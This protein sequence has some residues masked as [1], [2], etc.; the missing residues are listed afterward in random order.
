MVLT[1]FAAAAAFVG[2]NIDDI[3]VLT[4]LL[5]R[6]SGRWERLRV[7]AGYLSGVALLTVLSLL[8]AAGLR[9]V[10]GGWL[11][12]LGLIPIALGVRAA[13]ARQEDGALLNPSFIGAALITLGNGADNLGVY[14]ALFTRAAA[15]EAAVSSLVI[16]FMALAWLALAA[17]LAALEPLRRF[18]ERRSRILVPAVFLLLGLYILFL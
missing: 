10:S 14:A 3:L 17:Y 5:S 2:T 11:R 18:I 6:G 15:P 8:A 16:L 4:F 1:V 13:L 12:L 9:M 7:C